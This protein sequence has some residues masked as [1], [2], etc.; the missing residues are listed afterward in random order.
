MRDRAPNEYALGHNHQ[1]LQRLI[2]QGRW[3]G[4]LTEEVLRASGIGPGMR[5]LDVGCGAGDVSFLAATLVGATGSVVGV[6]RSA[7]AIA[8]AKRR[9]ADVGLANVSFVTQDLQDLATEARFDAIVGRLV[10]MYF[11]EPAVA[12]SR[13]LQLLVPGGVV[14]FHEIDVHGVTSEPPVPLLARSVTRISEAL[15]SSNAQPRMG[16]RLAQTF[17]QASL[18]TP[19]MIAHARIGTGADAATFQQ[20][21]GITRTLLPAMERH[22]IATAAEVDIDTL[23]ARLQRAV[24][25]SDATVVAPLFVGAWAH[26]Q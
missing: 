14:A 10:L 4:E 22:G 24:Q 8:L 13:L 25:T 19:R 5:V 11:P 16:L 1:E 18:P 23:A 12:L 26:K 7:E 6:D 17:Q 9:S 15:R 3:L 2:G 21:A 20:L